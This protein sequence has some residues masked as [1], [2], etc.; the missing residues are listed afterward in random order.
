MQDQLS[1]SNDDLRICDRNQEGEA[2][3]T[4]SRSPHPYH[5]KSVQLH[6]LSGDTSGTSTPAFSSPL[7]STTNTDDESAAPADGRHGSPPYN[8]S[9]DSDSGTEAD[10][11]HFLKGLPAPRLKGHKGLRNDDGSRSGSSSPLMSPDIMNDGERRLSGPHMQAV[12][13]A[14]RATN[15]ELLQSLK[16]IQTKRKIEV[17][18]RACE[19]VV[20]GAVGILVLS[21]DDARQVA[22]ESKKGWCPDQIISHKAHTLQKS[23]TLSLLSCL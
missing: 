10:D 20:L 12:L 17:R 23:H 7:R 1:R 16:R 11:E 9:T 18:R 8:Q 5:R 22:R 3:R 21:R 19:V 13:S 6:A 2:I 15:Q 4:L 14:Q